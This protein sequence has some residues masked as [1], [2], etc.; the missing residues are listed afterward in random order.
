MEE[1]HARSAVD[2]ASHAVFT[3]VPQRA[4]EDSNL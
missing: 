2:L 1:V 4:R 3:G